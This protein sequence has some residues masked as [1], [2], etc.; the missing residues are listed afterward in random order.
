L[1]ALGL[2]LWDVPGC[3]RAARRVLHLHAWLNVFRCFGRVPN[4]PDRRFNDYLYALK[5]SP[6]LESPLRRHL[7]DKVLSKTYIEARLGRGSAVPTLAVLA[8]AA[9][10]ATYCPPVF[11][12]AV[13]PTHSSG[14]IQKIGSP[15]DWDAARTEITGWLSHDYFR[16]S[17][18]R[19]YA[20]LAKRVIVEPW[21]DETLRY[22]GSVHCRAGVPKVVSIIDRYS[23]HRQSYTPDRRALGVSLAFPLREFAL[24]DWDF[25]DPLLTAA[26]RLSE[27]LSY[28]RVDF[29]TDGTRLL[30]GELTSIPAAGLGVFFPAGGEKIFSTAFFAPP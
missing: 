17:L 12:V 4:Q 29:Y 28:I 19:H 27:G 24:Q 8:E 3:R 26:A 30:F 23:K 20:D 1:A 16:L 10:I 6:E 11:P 5:V 21:L 2:F 9:E 15:K 14:R 25:F 22:E 18:E 13:K 7:T